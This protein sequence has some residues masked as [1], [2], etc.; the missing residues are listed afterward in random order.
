MQKK[1]S[2][3]AATNTDR[4]MVLALLQFDSKQQRPG[5]TCHQVRHATQGEDFV[6]SSPFLGP[7]HVTSFFTPASRTWLRSSSPS[8]GASFPLM[9]TSDNKHNECHCCNPFC[10]RRRTACNLLSSDLLSQLL[11]AL[12]CQAQ[13]LGRHLLDAR[14]VHEWVG[15]PP[16]ATASLH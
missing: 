4:C 2:A 13:A 8:F 5:N 9:C 16:L 1:A 12:L 14:A 3:R 7:P 10:T 6:L 15:G 11:A